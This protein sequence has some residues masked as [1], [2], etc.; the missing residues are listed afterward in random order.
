MS[1][2]VCNYAIARFRPYRETG[3]FVNVGVVLICP[4][5]NYFSSLFETRKHKRITDFFPELEINVFKA[6]LSGFLKELAR[7]TGRE[8]EEHLHQLVLREE[9]QASLARF[10]EFVR[11]RESLFHFGEAGTVLASD[12]RA[13]LQELF[14]YYIK[15][16]FARDREYQEMIMRRHLADFLHKNQLDS[17]YKEKPVG[18]DSYHVILPFVNIQ[19]VVVRKAIKPLHLDKDG[20]TEIYRYGDAWISSVKR[21]QNINRM[22]KELLFTIKEPKANQRCMA[23][24]ADIRQELEALDTLTIPFGETNRILEFAR[25]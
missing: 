6:G 18:D 21:L 8:H 23:A 16:Q 15:R 9:A 1:E 17:F 3:E 14:Q 20:P 22:P 7:V 19:G 10:R 11:P 2:V 25:L 13:K 12:P 5:V 24:A 4:Q